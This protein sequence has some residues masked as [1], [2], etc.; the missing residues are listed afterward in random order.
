M[1][2]SINTMKLEFDARSVNESFARA[3][4][5]AFA[6][7]LDPTLDEINDIKI[8]VSEAVTNALV[9]GYD[10]DKEAVGRRITVE[11][12]LFPTHINIKVSDNGKGIRDIQ[13]AMQPF[14]TTKPSDERAGMGFTV[15]QSF[16]DNLEVKSTLGI[17]T[18]IT[19]RKSIANSGR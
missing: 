8:A 16:M 9:H 2:T 12:T 11:A 19:M 15:M 7:Q 5:A 17:G 13:M 14:N 10:S 1:S 4:V 6:A 18:T 3:T